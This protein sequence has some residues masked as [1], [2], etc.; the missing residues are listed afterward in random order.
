MIQADI[1]EINTKDFHWEILLTCHLYW[2]LSW[3][4]DC[5]FF[6]LGDEPTVEDNLYS[7]ADIQ[8]IR[9]WCFCQT[10]YG[11]SSPST[12]CKLNSPSFWAAHEPYLLQRSFYGNQDTAPQRKKKNANSGMEMDYLRSLLQS[13]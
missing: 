8:Q 2:G 9:C 10:M 3:N 6:E 1:N 5:R 4:F 7:G 13:Q 12:S 11:L